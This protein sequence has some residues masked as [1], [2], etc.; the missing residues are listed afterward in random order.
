MPV[1]PETYHITSHYIA[2]LR[3]ADSREIPAA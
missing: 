1:S 2:S 3:I